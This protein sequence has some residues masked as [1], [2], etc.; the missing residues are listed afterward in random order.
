MGLFNAPGLDTPG[1]ESYRMSIC[2]REAQMVARLDIRK[3]P[4]HA[5]TLVAP[6]RSTRPQSHSYRPTNPRA[7]RVAQMVFNQPSPRAAQAHQGLP[8]YGRWCWGKIKQGIKTIVSPGL[9]VAGLWQTLRVAPSLMP[10]LAAVFNLGVEAVMGLSPY[11]LPFAVPVTAVFCGLVG[12]GLAAQYLQH[13]ALQAAR[14][15]ARLVHETAKTA[16]KTL[17]TSARAAVE[18][19]SQVSEKVFRAARDLW[20]SD[21]GREIRGIVTNMG[22]ACRLIVMG[23]IQAAHVLLSWAVRVLHWLAQTPQALAYALNVVGSYMRAALSSKPRAAC[24][25]TINSTLRPPS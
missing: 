10:N 7:A 17:D 13:K 22:K 11:W 21:F 20:D 18:K 23:A 19:V 14:E 25:N 4:M 24:S 2:Y 15:A 1:F 9:Q 12:I 6:R 8:A 16:M 5:Q 3:R